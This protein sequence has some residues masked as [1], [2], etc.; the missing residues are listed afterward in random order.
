METAV[1]RLPEDSR[2]SGHITFS[3]CYELFTHL[4]SGWSDLESLEEEPGQAGRFQR[5][6][7]SLSDQG[8]TNVLLV[9]VVTMCCISSFLAAGLAIVFM[10]QESS[11]ALNTNMQ[12]DLSF[13]QGNLEVFTSNIFRTQQEERTEMF[14][15]TLASAFESISYDNQMDAVGTKL[16]QTVTAV[17]TTLSAWLGADPQAHFTGLGLLMALMAEQSLLSSGLDLTA[18]TLNGVNADLPGGFEVLLGQWRGNGTNS[19]EYLTTFRFPNQC[20]RSCV[21]DDVTTAPMR[22]ALSGATSAERGRDYRGADVYAGYSSVGGLGVEVSVD[23]SRMEAVRVAQIRAAL[24]GLNAAAA[25]S[26]EFLLGYIPTPGAAILPLMTL[27]GCDAACVQ[28]AVAPRGPLARA[29]AGESGV[30][31]APNARGLPSV[32]AFAPVLVGPLRIGLVLWMTKEE[33]SGTA[34]VSIAALVDAMNRAHPVPTEEFELTRFRTANGTAAFDHLTAYKYAAECPTGKCALADFIKQAAKNCSQ[35]VLQTTDYRGERV[36]AGTVCIPSLGAVLSF[37]TDVDELDRQALN[38]ITLAV[39]DRNDRDT[40]TSA[41]YLLAA[42]KPGLTAR[43]VS[44]YDD[45]QLMSRIKYP[46]SCIN[47]NCTWNR[48]S[49]L[50]ALQDKEEVVACHD[51]RDMP[52][53]AAPAR[54]YAVEQGIGLALELDGSEFMQPIVDTAIEV[55]CFSVGMVFGSTAV[56]VLMTKL[57]LR[58]MIAAKEEGKRAVEAEKDRFSKL[59]ASMYPAYVLPRLLE[60][61]KQM[62]CEVPGAAVFFSDI[63][64]FTPVSNTLGSQKLLQLMGYVY[65]VMDMIADWYGV[66]KVKVI[67]DAYLAVTGLPGSDAENP[68]LDLLRFASCVCQVFGTRFVH[69]SEGSVL[70]ILNSRARGS[71][72]SSASSHQTG[73]TRHSA[74]ALGRSPHGPPPPALSHNPKG[75]PSSRAPHN[76]L[77]PRAGQAQND[78]LLAGNALATARHS[79]LTDT[80]R[81]A[82]TGTTPLPGAVPAVKPPLP[83]CSSEGSFGETD[84]S[85]VGDTQVQ[86]VMSY[87]LAAGRLVAGVLAGRCP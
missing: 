85:H 70:S 23:R 38:I 54:S 13:V 79:R 68:G 8:A 34:L 15:V 7:A 69:P 19:V 61:E 46:D 21:V 26:S 49:A 53:V 41:E 43:E 39:D 1:L 80:S 42:P 37:K 67:G 31:E 47:P 14:V 2:A 78:S 55:A 58:S 29:I 18:A 4:Q 73:S 3:Q 59:V 27:R 66:Y 33:L 77:S 12:Q 22:A 32:A 36:L 87:G 44:G 28:R 72:V 75:P 76:P 62:V 5:W 82:D 71:T 10:I 17:A 30:V 20:N 11:Q 45:F 6:M 74:H 40:D 81:G 48:K 35:G 60:G 51:Y 25:D 84:C 52:V 56:L 65:G 83:A 63:H 24:E 50:L 64:E 57:L 16:Q 9:L 86:C